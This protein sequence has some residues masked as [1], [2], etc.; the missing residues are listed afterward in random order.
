MAAGSKAGLC[1]VKP[2][3]VSRRT[4]AS[5]VASAKGKGKKAAGGAG[6]AT[7]Q[8]SAGSKSAPKEKDGAYQHETRK[9]ILSVDK[10]RR[11]SHLLVQ[12]RLASW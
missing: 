3:L 8:R 1:R 2:Y 4:E 10:L 6:T 11:V 12:F 5:V 7:K 9:I